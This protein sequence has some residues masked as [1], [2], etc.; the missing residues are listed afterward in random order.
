MVESVLAPVGVLGRPGRPVTELVLP[1]PSSLAPLPQGLC[2]CLAGW[3]LCSLLCFRSLFKSH[4]SGPS[5]PLCEAHPHPVLCALL[6]VLSTGHCPVPY[7]AYLCLAC[8]LSCPLKRSLLEVG[9]RVLSSTVS[10]GVGGWGYGGV[11][12]LTQVK[13]TVTRDFV[14]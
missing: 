8:H 10:R 9:V 11:F 6:A 12:M 1:L 14:F 5:L 7:L 13:L 3:V 2:R 4:H